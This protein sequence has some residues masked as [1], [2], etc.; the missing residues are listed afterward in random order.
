METENEKKEISQADVA[1]ETA[2]MPMKNIR[3][4][5]S[6]SE[7]MGEAGYVVGRHYDAVKNAFLAYVT[8]D[9]KAKRV[10]SRI[11]RSGE[12]FYAGNKLIAMLSLTGSTLRL[13]MA[14]DPKEY[15]ADKYHHRDYS[16][17]RRYIKIP[18][19]I[20]LSSPRQERYAVEL[21]DELLVSCGFVRDVNYSEKDQANVFKKPKRKR[22]EDFKEKY[23]PVTDVAA[24]A[25]ASDAVKTE[26]INVKLPVRASVRDKSGDAK[27]KIRKS[28]WTDENGKEQGVFVKNE[29]NV[30][31]YEKDALKGYVD[32]ND[33]ILTL[34]DGYIATIVRRPRF[35][36]P[37]VII[38]LACITLIS[39]IL[40]TYFITRS[41]NAGPPVL[42]MA[43]ED[44]TAWSDTENLPVFVNE[45]FGDSKIAP[46]MSG[47]YRFLFENRNSSKVTY[48]L[49]FSEVNDYGIKLLYRLKRDGAYL[50]GR[51]GYVSVG[52][53]GVE[54]LTI[55][56]RSSALF[57]LE[58]HWQD[59]DEADT[60]AGENSAIYSLNISFSAYIGE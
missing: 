27:G 49:D 38:V 18:F 28:V 30:F 1:A 13:F 37:V 57:E 41:E 36:V 15:N 10:R 9:R 45:I 17:R 60:A 2:V 11:S 14:L 48:S 22:K 52:D 40:C 4:G 25:V 43:S 29:K 55:E 5:S 7:R 8:A 56:G 16:E 21:I 6:F 34:S 54:G 31:L 32:K 44:G 46:G 3:S 39:A 19:M 42:F 26:Q 58:W 47:D 33:N 50:T 12:K 20:R 51:E 35:I 23:I 24:S 53:L 59:S